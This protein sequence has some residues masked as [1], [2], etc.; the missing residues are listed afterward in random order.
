MLLPL[1]VGPVTSTNPCSF[2]TARRYRS[3]V[4]AQF[5]QRVES[6]TLVQKANH[7]SFAEA[8]GHRCDTQIDEPLTNLNCSSTVLR[9]PFF[10]DVHPAQHFDACQYFFLDGFGKCVNI[11][12]NA[13]DPHADSH[14]ILDRL[15]MN[16]RC[17]CSDGFRMVVPDGPLNH[18]SIRSGH[19]KSIRKS[20]FSQARTQW[21]T[22]PRFFFVLADPQPLAVSH[23]RVLPTAGLLASGTVW[24][25]RQAFPAVST[26]IADDRSERLNCVAR[27]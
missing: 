10:G 5:L 24:Q 6:G 20:S 18:M 11:K 25:D 17:S 26:G 27:L 19:R 12:Q 21:S 13:I 23:E 3:S 8:G 14:T 4:H 15:D 9:Q 22:K 2:R 16:I 7:N 1:P